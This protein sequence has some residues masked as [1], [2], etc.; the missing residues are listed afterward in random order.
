MCFVSWSAATAANAIA[1]SATH[2][3]GPAASERSANETGVSPS[4]D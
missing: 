1:A 4:V 3:S 2:C